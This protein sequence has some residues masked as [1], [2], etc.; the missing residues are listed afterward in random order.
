MESAELA[1]RRM[2]RQ[3]RLEQQLVLPALV[4]HRLGFHLQRWPRIQ[5]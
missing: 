3:Q 2:L 1:A 4:Q 5:T